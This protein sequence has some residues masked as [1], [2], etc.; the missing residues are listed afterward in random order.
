MKER[1]ILFSGAMVRAILDGSKT[2]TRRV[3]THRWRSR[4]QCE[5]TEAHQYTEGWVISRHCIHG[6]GIT[7]CPY[8]HPGD[9]LWVR[10]TWRPWCDP[11]ELTCVQY[12]ADAGVMKPDTWDENQGFWCE[13]V[14]DENA[15]RDAWGM[16][17]RWRPSMHMPRWASRITLEIVGV[18]V[19]RLQ[20]IT[21]ADAV[22]EGCKPIV[23]SQH[24]LS[25]LG[26]F[27]SVWEEI[28]AKRGY[29][30]DINPWVWVI[31][32]TVQL[33]NQELTGGTSGQA[34]VR[35]NA[36]GCTTGGQNVND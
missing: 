16:T 26:H 8:G 20:E 12:R 21:E 19:E 5:H 32:F 35:G 10:E 2:Q 18:R 23:L 36:G 27:H 34:A 9:R 22:K 30:W 31:E 13:S 7:L 24:N 33:A 11:E 29:G 3:A 15:E 17:P 14:G 6:T 28:N 25:G 1:P 4:R